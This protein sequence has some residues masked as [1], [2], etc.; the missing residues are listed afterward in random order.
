LVKRAR[1]AFPRDFARIWALYAALCVALGV[2]L[3]SAACGGGAG[4]A[5]SEDPYGPRVAQ[6]IDSPRGLSD[7]AIDH[8]IAVPPGL[9]V[10]GSTRGEREQAQ[11]DYGPGGQQLFTDEAPARRAH[12]AGFRLDRS[13]VTN[14]ELAEILP[15]CGMVPPDVESISQSTW[16]QL[17]QRFGLRAGYD[18]VVR[19]LWTGPKPPP[20]RAEHPMVLV[21][22]DEAAFYCAWRGGRL[23]TA[24]EWERAARGQTG[25]V[26]PWGPSFD[27]F[28]A[29]VAL[30]GAGDTIAVGNRPTGNTSE[31][32]TDMGGHVLEWTSTR[33]PGRDGYAIVKGN[34]WDGRGGYG[35]GAASRALP[36]DQ[37][38]I[39]LGFRCAM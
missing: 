14:A 27:P 34:G 31:G 32:F 8:M 10:L 26:Y 22:F 21:T 3:P 36:V 30:R 37:R 4:P 28:R 33:A 17:A 23:P 18:E 12:V 7:A 9:A 39:N 5:R 2:L 6:C 15:G 19:F 11:R 35:R 20:L 13:P 25:S 24:Q 1:H 29:N 16:Q 38:D